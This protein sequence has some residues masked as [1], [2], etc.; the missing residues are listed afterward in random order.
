MR[1]PS[2]Y[3]RQRIDRTAIDCGNL[4]QKTKPK[5]TGKPVPPKIDN[6]APPPLFETG[7]ILARTVQCG[8]G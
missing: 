3:L 8:E 5:S 7:A 4:H 1:L 6:S 2:A